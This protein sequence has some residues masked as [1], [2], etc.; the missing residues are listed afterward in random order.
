MLS[1]PRPRRTFAGASEDATP[2]L[3]AGG[4]KQSC[5]FQELRRSMIDEPTNDSKFTTFHTRTG[6]RMPS[7]AD[8]HPRWRVRMRRA[9]HSA[10]AG[11]KDGRPRFFLRAGRADSSTAPGRRGMESSLSVALGRSG[12]GGEGR[13]GA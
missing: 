2:S 9:M 12:A 4:G 6:T 11:E 3:C 8:A 1:S 13:N 10:D 7:R 5:V